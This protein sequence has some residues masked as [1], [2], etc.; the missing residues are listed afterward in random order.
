MNH[1]PTPV[2][3]VI[4]GKIKPGKMAMAKRE[5]EANIKIVMAKEPACHGIRVYDDP[6]NPQQLLII[7]NW[8]SEEVFNGP[9]MQTPHMQTFFKKAEEFLDGE[10]GFRFWHEIITSNQ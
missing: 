3:V 8:D 6:K 4:T 1:N 10:A 9:H 7:E 2:T 5:L